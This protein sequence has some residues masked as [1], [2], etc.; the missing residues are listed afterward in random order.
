MICFLCIKLEDKRPSTVHSGS[1]LLEYLYGPKEMS[2]YLCC[3]KNKYITRER[4]FIPQKFSVNFAI[5]IAFTHKSF[6][7]RNTSQKIF[8]ID[9]DIKR[10]VPIIFY[11]HIN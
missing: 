7:T 10:N 5:G 2:S 3:S 4:K 11:I 8:R 1:Q 9:H 6:V